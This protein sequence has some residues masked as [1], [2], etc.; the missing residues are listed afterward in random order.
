MP[1]R[2]TH[3]HHGR[4]GTNLHVPGRNSPSLGPE[5]ADPLQYRARQLRMELENLG[6]RYA[7]FAL[8]LSSRIDLLP[9]EY[10][11]ELALAADASA[12][13]LPSEIYRLLTDELGSAFPQEFEDFDYHPL[14]ST[15]IRQSHSARLMTGNLVTVT[16][17][18][19]EYHA[20]QG[21]Q[22]LKAFLDQEIIDRL[23]GEIKIQDVVADF[24]YALRRKTNLSLEKEALENASDTADKDSYDG[25]ENQK[26][27]H[28]LSTAHVLTMEKIESRSLDQSMAGPSFPRDALARR[29]CK[30]WLEL[31][32]SGGPFPVD[33]Q[34]HN[35]AVRKN[36]RLSFEGC[37]L[38]KLPKAVRENLRN[39]LL[40]A[41][42]DD[43]DRSAACLLHEMYSAGNKKIDVQS[44]RTNFR[45]SAYFA[46]L[47]PILGADSNSLA[48]LVFQHWKTALDHGYFPKPLL[49]CFYRGLFSVARIARKIADSEDAMRGGVEELQTEK[50]FSEV[51]E[52]AD[53]RYWIQNSD[54]FA[55][56]L[57]NLPRTFDQALTRASLPAREITVQSG[58]DS[59]PRNIAV[60]VAIFLLIVA[61]LVSQSAHLSGATEKIVIGVLMLAGLLTLRAL[62]G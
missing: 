8:Y 38:A 22:A 13:L 43:P 50:I 4:H 40:A 42:V 14:S 30:V 60:V 17:L 54:K 61:V 39:Y 23:C 52:L 57:V 51:R 18:R 29:I 46:A 7:C 47:E 62:S 12:P 36:D 53:L 27:Y 37:E 34:E 11:R 10:C 31:A 45:Q 58:S 26:I 5:I 20:L 24:L 41:V 35:V 32:M 59:R 1:M 49:L 6:P 21:D 25:L 28:E 44:F 3:R 55:G 19:P 15:L 48:Q 9:A 16:F 33:P 56:I 2:W